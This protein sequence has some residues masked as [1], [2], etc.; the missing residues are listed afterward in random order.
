MNLLPVIVRELRAQSRQPM[1]YWLRVVGIGVILGVI[2]LVDSR[3]APS[4]LGGRYFSALNAALFLSIWIFVPLL[5]ADAISREKREGTLG[6][7]FLTPLTPI[8][9]VFGKSLIHALRAI[10]LFLAVLPALALPF[11]LGGLTWKDCAVSLLLNSSA[12]VLALAAGLLASTLVTDSRRALALALV[13]SFGLAYL[14]MFVHLQIFYSTLPGFLNLRFPFPTDFAW[15]LPDNFISQIQLL[16]SF[17][18]GLGSHAYGYYGWGGMAPGEGWRFVWL[19][20]PAPF[21]IAWLRELGWLFIKSVIAFAAIGGLASWRIR[22]TWR[23]EPP[24]LRKAQVQKFFCAPR[25]WKSI[26]R[27]K[28][29]GLLT[30]NPIGWLQQYSWS[31]RVVKWGWC[32]GIVLAECVV[33]TDPSLSN[34]WDG[35]YMLAS[36]LILGIAFTASGSF[37][38]ECETGAMELLLITPLKVPRIL[39]GRIRG[40]WGQF[41]P[42]TV[43]LALAWLWLLKDASLFAG[44]DYTSDAVHRQVFS[45]VLP[46]F[47]VSSFLLLPG[48]GLLFSM[49]RLHFIGAWL[50]TCA[51]GLLLPALSC[52][53]MKGRGLFAV[54]SLF[55]TQ[56][57]LALISRILLQRHL[58]GR[59]FVLN[60][61]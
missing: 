53:S 8:G 36:L 38:E 27:S 11:L 61:A 37:R 3:G 43:V 4:E 56:W 2:T 33:I 32:L 20:Y 39:G 51:T 17:N 57:V 25:I 30:R 21:H 23:L 35:Q 40:V 54:A 16:I 31:A 28:M 44:Y 48:I 29:T 6:L 47:F 26:F 55:A 49:Q 19:N 18:T 41:L 10:T 45:I 34:V 46:L 9:I 58:T 15:F 60:S 50:L 7:L 52:W 12:L 22:R 5:T 13:L 1:T 42:A 14:F 59:R 24:S